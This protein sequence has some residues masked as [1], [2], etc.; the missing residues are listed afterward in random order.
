ML[1]RETTI[2][3][4]GEEITVFMQS[5]F[6]DFSRL[7]SPPHKHSYTELQIILE[8]NAQIEV[9]NTTYSLEKDDVLL[10]PQEHYHTRTSFGKDTKIIS[11]L[12]TKDVGQCTVIKL[13]ERLADLLA[14][15]IV[16]YNNG[17][18][19]AKMHLYLSL[20]C[21]EILG[22]DSYHLIPIR[23]RG[24]LIDEFFSKNYNQ[25]SSLKKLAEIL[26]L[27]EKQ[28]ERLVKAHT[29]NNFRDEM[30]CRRIETAKHL[31]KRERYSLSEIAELVGYQSYSGFWK[32]FN[33]YSNKK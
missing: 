7:I 32:A 11:F 9:A 27:S 30:T 14:E 19:E 31:M 24:F 16:A 25:P 28:T 10:I 15:E 1:Y 4:K 33:N 12:I 20:L 2:N 18:T 22:T 8:G 5:G 26:N 23:D 17:A 6:F 13:P 29:G 21:A 3:L